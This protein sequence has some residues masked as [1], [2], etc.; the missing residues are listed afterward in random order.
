MCFCNKCNRKRRRQ[1]Y[2]EP[3][4]RQAAFDPVIEDCGCPAVPAVD[5]KVIECGKDQQIIKH[6]HI[7]KHQHDIINEY[8]II[9]E[10]E[11]NYYD[12]VAER[13]VVKNNDFCNYKPEYCEKTPQCSCLRCSR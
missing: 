5:E 11:Y 4:V 7:V 8:E 9:H 2:Y 13:E 10:H 1:N 3:M 6:K 12:V